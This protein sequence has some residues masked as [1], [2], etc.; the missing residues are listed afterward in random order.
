MSQRI[1]IRLAGDDDGPAIDR[2]A[3]LDSKRRPA[4]GVL[5]AE[6]DGEP[7]A[8]LPLEGGAV[9]ADPFH[10]TAD[11]VALLELRARQLDAGKQSRPG[12]ARVRV[13]ALP[14]RLRTAPAGGDGPRS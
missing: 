3:A 12:G 4:G 2:L 5:L 7:R 6:V 13:R 9:V 8:A 11:L 14:L 1:E 10:P